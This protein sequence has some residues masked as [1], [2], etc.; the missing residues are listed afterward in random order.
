MI[1]SLFFNGVQ[2]LRYKPYSIFIL[3]ET[4]RFFSNKMN[5]S[6]RRQ[7]RNIL[8]QVI[9]YNMYVLKPIKYTI[10]GFRSIYM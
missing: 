3:S 5:T 10:K 6:V 2:I 7:V 1:K 8:F 4:S 9:A